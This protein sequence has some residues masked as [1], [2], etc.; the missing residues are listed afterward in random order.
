MPGLWKDDSLQPSVH[1]KVQDIQCP[2]C[3]LTFNNK[4]KCET[5]RGHKDKL[6]SVMNV[7]FQAKN[8]PN[9]KQ[10]IKSIHDEKWSSQRKTSLFTFITIHATIATIKQLN[11]GNKW[12]FCII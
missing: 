7:S 11:S 2:E 5:T 3:G 12:L 8:G 6:S 10:N 1:D 4:R 9:L